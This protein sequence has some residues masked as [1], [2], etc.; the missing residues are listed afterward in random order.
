MQQH[1]LKRRAGEL[2]D[3][4][5]Q[6]APGGGAA[7]PHRALASMVQPDGS[8]V[9]KI[10][11]RAPAL[12]IVPFRFLGL[13]DCARL[14][15]ACR[16]MRGTWTHALGRELMCQKVAAEADRRCASSADSDKIKNYE[17]RAIQAVLRVAWSSGAHTGYACL[18]QTA[19]SGA[20]CALIHASS[21]MGG[22]AC[23]TV[24]SLGGVGVV[25]QQMRDFRDNAVLQRRACSTLAC[26]ATGPNDRAMEHHAR[27]VLEA[28]GL[29][30][31]LEA[32]DVHSESEA[33]I[34]DACYALNYLSYGDAN[35]SMMIKSTAIAHILAAMRSFPQ[36]SGLLYWACSALWV[37]AFATEDGPDAI[38]HAGGIEQ[39]LVVAK[40]CTDAGVVEQACF[41]LA[42][43]AKVSRHLP[44]LRLTGA[45]KVL[46]NARASLAADEFETDVPFSSVL[47]LLQKR[48]A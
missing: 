34:S 43:I 39:C 25:L 7:P 18:L 40:S 15:A 11:L 29:P 14:A 32:M 3:P 8:A 19:V 31:I 22:S 36:S 35:S 41:V 2:C 20:L 13:A 42:D 26:M 12:R 33:A 47:A 24:V 44:Q 6:H 30:L 4:G 17:H 45:A 21:A 9:E 23:T 16:W 48:G 27:V 37:N 5:K 46:E 28:G 1:S 10:H 38:V